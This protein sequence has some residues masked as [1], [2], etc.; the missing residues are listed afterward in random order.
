MSAPCLRFFKDE[1]LNKAQTDRMNELWT[2]FHDDN[3]KW[4]SRQECLML[5]NAENFIFVFAAFEGQ[6]FE[7]I[8][9]LNNAKYFSCL[10]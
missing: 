3:P 7:Y 5:K 1:N 6:A 4:I 10:K 8:R 9:T 2:L